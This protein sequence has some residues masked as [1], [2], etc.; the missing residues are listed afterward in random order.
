MRSV[1]LLVCLLIVYGSLF[2]FD[3]RP[4]GSD[5]WG[6][7]LASWHARPIRSDIL[8]NIVLFLPFGYFGVLAW[9]RRWWLVGLA[10]ALALGLQLLQLYLP[11]RD[12]NF[13]DVVWNLLGTGAGAVL[14]ALP[15]VHIPGVKG[16]LQHGEVFVLLLLGAWL[17]YRLLPFVPSLDW[18]QIKDSLKPLLL[19]PRLGW[20]DV[21]R[22]TAGW[23][24][25]AALWPVLWHGRRPWGVLATAAACVL[26][27]EVFIVANSVSAANV[28]GLV[29]GLLLWRG[30]QGLPGR[31]GVLALVL[32]VTLLVE[33]FTPFRLRQAAAAF[34]WQPFYGFLGGSMLHNIASLFEKIFLYGSL[35]WLARRQ[36][37]R[38]VPALALTLGVTLFIEWGQV[39]LAGHTPEITDPLLVLC[40][41]LVMEKTAVPRTGSDPGQVSRG[42]VGS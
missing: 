26:L 25:V 1:F 32:V 24:T 8:S 3:F 33:G 9:G 30:L 31:Y 27:M 22:N 29:L 17:S 34:H 14:A 16:R 12:A 42:E 11:S 6:Q 23:A 39:H 19:H 5:A 28:L 21:L 41:A 7:L 15:I 37:G 36:W 38:I 18:Q 13:L 2:P 35:L 40:L 4:M 10:L 20:A